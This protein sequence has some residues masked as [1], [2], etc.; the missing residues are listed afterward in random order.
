MC[1]I[2]VASSN[3]QFKKLLKFSLSLISN[4]LY[5][6]Q[7]SQIIEN[8]MIQENVT[9]QTRLAPSFSTLLLGMNIHFQT[10]LNVPENASEKNIARALPTGQFFSIMAFCHYFKPFLLIIFFYLQNCHFDSK[11]VNQGKN[12]Q[13][14]IFHTNFYAS[15]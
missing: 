2:F 14:V 3:L 10:Y 1:P 13:S 4:L 7:H 12:L 15:N 11:A 6:N 8:S 9:I 5:L